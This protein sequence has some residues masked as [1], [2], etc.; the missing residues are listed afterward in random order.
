MK[1]QN[2]VK[3]KWYQQT[4]WIIFLLIV[5]FPVGLFLMWKYTNWNKWLKIGITLFF[6][7]AL[8]SPSSSKNNTEPTKNEEAYLTPT[9]EPTNT[10]TPEPTATPTPTPTVTPTPTITPIPTSTPTPEPTPEQVSE[11]MVW[12]SGSGAKYHSNPSCSNMSAPTEITISD[13]ESRG[14]EPCKK[15]Y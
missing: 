3:K 12:V 2:S 6:V 1:V 9:P 4:G 15:C 8:F 13:A 10:P 14:Y 11:E 7:W 5:F